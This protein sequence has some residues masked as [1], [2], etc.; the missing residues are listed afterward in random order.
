MKVHTRIMLSLFFCVAGMAA[1]TF[2]SISLKNDATEEVSL[3]QK[4]GLGGAVFLMWVAAFVA[5]CG[6]KA[7]SNDEQKD[8]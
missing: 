6:N 5:I 1:M 2:V 3:G 4:I 8:K 7:E